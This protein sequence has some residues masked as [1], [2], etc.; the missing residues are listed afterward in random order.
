MAREGVSP[1]WIGGGLALTLLASVGAGYWL[2]QRAPSVEAPPQLVSDSSTETDEE[3]DAPITLAPEKPELPP[4]MESD[5]FVREMALQLSD[6]PQVAK[7]VTPDGLVQR[8]VAS[9]DNIA[10]GDSPRPHLLHM[11]PET[12]FQV[13]GDQS[14]G[15][16]RGG[17][18]GSQGTFAVDPRT[19][20]R[21]NLMT[22]VF[23]SLDIGATVRLYYEMEPLLEE[24]YLELGDPSRSFAETLD[25]AIGRLLDT[26]VPEALPDVEKH[27]LN[28]RFTDP[29]MERL[30]PAAKHLMRLGPENAQKVKGKL[31]FLRA[32]LDLGRKSQEN[33]AASASSAD[34]ASESASDNP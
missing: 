26:E 4:L 7:W 33:F 2:I 5:A 3:T 28:Y 24:A 14:G 15:Q 31:S 34:P 27:L 1:W 25:L 8:L 16:V 11:E 22:E 30:S 21:Y 20:E 6:H 13:Q 29:D 19:F 18:S 12:P 17:Q 32:A 10:R 23:V 9:V